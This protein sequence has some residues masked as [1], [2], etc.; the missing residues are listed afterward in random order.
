V[1][2]R[3]LDIEKRERERERERE[4][5]SPRPGIALQRRLM[6]LSALVV[7]EKVLA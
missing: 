4:G 7:Q 5:E 2:A 1:R 6:L 3:E